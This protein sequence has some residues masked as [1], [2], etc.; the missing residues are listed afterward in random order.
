MKEFCKVFWETMVVPVGLMVGT[1]MIIILFIG[2]FRLI[3]WI[4]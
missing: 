2:A 1:L 4:A 3:E